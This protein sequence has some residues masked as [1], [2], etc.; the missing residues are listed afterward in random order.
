MRLGIAAIVLAAA[1][2]GFAIGAAVFASSGSTN[3]APS[4]SWREGYTT[5]IENSIVYTGT[6]SPTVRCHHA[7]KAFHSLNTSVTRQAIKSQ[8]VTACILGDTP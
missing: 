4:R 3:G 2:I 7:W 1:L 6:E 8:W 5:G